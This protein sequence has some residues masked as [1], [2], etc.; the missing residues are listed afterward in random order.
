MKIFTDLS[1]LRGVKMGEIN[2]PHLIAH[3]VNP[4]IVQET[5]GH[6]SLETTTIY[7]AMAKKAQRQALQEHA[8]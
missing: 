5:L 2:N 6:E 3:G 8:L 1:E 7:V 4:R